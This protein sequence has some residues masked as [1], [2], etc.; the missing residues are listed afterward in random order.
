MSTPAEIIGNVVDS[1]INSIHTA[2]IGIIQSY[3]P[4]TNRA[5]IQPALNVKYLTQSDPIP[6]PVIENVPIIFP[7]SS[8]FS[9]TFPVNPGDYCLLVFIERSIDL[10]K[11]VGGQVT[12]DDP[13]KYNLSDCVAIPGLLP[14]NA[15]I[16][17]NAGNNFSIIFAGS[18]IRI[19]ANGNVIIKT[20]NRVGIGNSTTEVLDVVSRLMQL[21]RGATVMGASFGGP[22][23][24]TFVADV[25]LLQTELDDIKV[26]IT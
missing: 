21:L 26:A 24:P 12:P 2:N 17:E 9:I 5:T 19:D 18:Q 20:G 8:S 11:A 23:S 4:S 3:D 25:L 22:L 16:P 14:F 6:L 15:N 10:W 7:W 13:R 1:R